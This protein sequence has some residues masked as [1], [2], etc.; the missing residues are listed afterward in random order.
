MK[1]GKLQSAMT[2]GLEQLRKP[3]QTIAE[4]KKTARKLYDIADCSLRLSTEETLVQQAEQTE[5]SEESPLD[6]A[7]FSQVMSL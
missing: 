4:L 5:T 6:E 2:A 3:S 1:L 7:Q